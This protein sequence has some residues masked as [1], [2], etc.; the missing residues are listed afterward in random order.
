MIKL[1]K[2]SILRSQTVLKSI[3]QTRTSPNLRK[4]KKFESSNLMSKSRAIRT[5]SVNITLTKLKD[6]QK[7][8]LL[9]ERRSIAEHLI[10][11]KN[12]TINNLKRKLSQIILS[13]KSKIL[14]RKSPNLRISKI[15][16][17][18]TPKLSLKNSSLTK[19]HQQIT[20]TNVG[21]GCNSLGCA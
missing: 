8:F 2:E 17:I 18:F 21:F 14:K 4:R 19:N 11:K 20:T 10:M 9:K 3:I 15:S 12:R 5:T 13:P 7:R 6:F 1:S 16:R